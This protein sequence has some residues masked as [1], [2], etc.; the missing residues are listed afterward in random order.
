MASRMRTAAAFLVVALVLCTANATRG[1]KGEADSLVDPILLYILGLEAFYEGMFEEAV[2]LLEDALSATWWVPQDEAKILGI[3]GDCYTF[4]FDYQAAIGRYNLSLDLYHYYSS[5]DPDHMFYGLVDDEIRVNSLIGLGVVHLQL[6][7]TEQAIRYFED[8]LSLSR[9]ADR[10]LQKAISLNN[11]GIC[12]AKI[13]Q[14]DRAV[15]SFTEALTLFRTIPYQEGEATALTNLGNVYAGWHSP[16]GYVRAI[17]CLDEGLAIR[18]EI[19]DKRGEA[20]SLASLGNF[21]HLLGDDQKALGHYLEALDIGTVVGDLEVQWRAHRGIGQ[22]EWKRGELQEAADHYR[23]AVELVEAIRSSVMT[24]SLRQSYLVSVRD[25]YE[26]YLELLF[27]TENGASMLWYAERCRARSLL[28]LLEYGGV[29]TADAFEGM[30]TQGTVDAAGIQLLLDG[31]PALLEE[32]EALIPYA[33]G[34]DHLFM[35]VVTASDGIQ[36]PYAEEIDYDEALERIYTFRSRLEASVDHAAVRRDLEWLSG[37]LIEPVT[38]QIEGYGTWV[39]VPSGPLW[40][41]PYAALRLPQTE[42]Y[43]IEEHVI[44]YAPSVASLAT[45]LGK[46]E[47][48]APTPTLALVNPYR[49]DL[50]LLPTDLVEAMQAF[51]DATG[52]GSIYSEEEA[53]EE[54]IYEVLPSESVSSSYDYLAFACHGIFRYGNP[55]YSYLALTPTEIEEGNLEAREVLSLGLEG[56]ELVLLVACETFLTAVETRNDTAGVGHELSREQKLAILRDLM[57]GDE[58]VGL[59]RSFLLSGAESVLATLWELYV[60]TAQS[61]LPSLGERLE[62]GLPRGRAVQDVVCQ[63]LHEEQARLG[64]DPWTGRPYLDD[65]WIWA[66]FILVGDWR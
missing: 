29:V 37:L 22:A 28:D 53:S 41:V 14:L 63:V 10:A 56:T 3:L 48:V 7:D 17:D 61:F 24:E 40:Y 1:E 31:A 15:E 43:V 25:V 59:S 33:W 8:V 16:A 57:R 46:A 6:G 50:P 47:D 45:I 12:F 19:G 36:G 49:G 38:N 54:L 5:F 55:L 60:P 21:Y 52:G 35:W 66:P 44:A 39:V 23:Q 2:E 42:S 27:D 58:L 9:E 20:S 32:D 65:P 11:L 13:T 26:E 62:R 4:M 64:I 51:V 34:T 30:T 18:R